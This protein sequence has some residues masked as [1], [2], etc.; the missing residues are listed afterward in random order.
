MAPPR[1]IEI[2]PSLLSADLTRLPTLLSD[3]LSGGAS[4]VSVDV[5]DGHFVPNLSFGPDFLR[6]VK[7]LAPASQVDVHLMVTN[8]G[9]VAPWFVQAGADRVTFH[10]EA[11]SDARGLLR[12]LRRQGVKAGVAVKPGTSETGLMPLLDEADV[13]LIMTVEPGF[14]GAKFLE[15]MLPKISAVRRAVDARRLDCRVQVDGGINL[16]TIDVAAGA[17]ADDLVAG[18]GVFGTPDP[19]AAVR[20]LRGRAQTAFDRRKI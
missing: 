2:V 17:G 20:A 13:A 3:V 16:A 19:T 6:L 7:R 4:W 14:G 1:S 10:L 9:D 5:M 15:A 18:Q 8:P 12:A 11:A